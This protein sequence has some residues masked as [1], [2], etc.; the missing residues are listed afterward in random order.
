MQRNIQT[1]L[2]SIGIH[3][4]VLNHYNLYKSGLNI[5]EQFCKKAIDK[6]NRNLGA[7]YVL[8]AL[9]IVSPEAADALPWLFQS[10]S[11]AL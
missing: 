8:C 10:V 1:I 2:L 7:S 5:I 4:S 3:R 11:N 6:E 9:T